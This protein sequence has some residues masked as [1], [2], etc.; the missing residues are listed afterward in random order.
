M[1]RRP[2]ITALD[3]P[4]WVDT[5]CQ[6]KRWQ[7]H[8]IVRLAIRSGFSAPVVANAMGMG[9]RTVTRIAAAELDAEELSAEEE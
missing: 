2:Q 1:R 8:A 4:D 6:L 9:V 3:A 5:P 7:R